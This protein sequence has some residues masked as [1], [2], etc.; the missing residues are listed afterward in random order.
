MGVKMDKPVTSDPVVV[1]AFRA[2]SGLMVFWG[3]FAA[4]GLWPGVLVMSVCALLAKMVI[5]ARLFRLLYPEE[6]RVIHD[7][8]ADYRKAKGIDQASRYKDLMRARHE[9]QRPDPSLAYQVAVMSQFDRMASNLQTKAGLKPASTRIADYRAC[10]R[11]LGFEGVSMDLTKVPLCAR[12]DKALL[13][14]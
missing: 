10:V 9:Y 3:L 1:V 12:C 14:P 2:F 5:T 6:P 8:A 13:A 4:L 7:I 11:C